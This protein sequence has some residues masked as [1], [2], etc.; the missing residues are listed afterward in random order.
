[1]VIINRTTCCNLR[2]CEFE[3]MTTLSHW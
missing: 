1:L 3:G 2:V